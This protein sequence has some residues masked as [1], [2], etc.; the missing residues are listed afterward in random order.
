MNATETVLSAALVR[1]RRAAT[2]RNAA[3]PTARA[4]ALGVYPC[5][6]GQHAGR[7]S[8]C[9]RSCRHVPGKELPAPAFHDGRPGASPPRARVRGCA[10][11]QAFFAI[12]LSLCIIGQTKL[13]EL[14]HP[15][16]RAE[17]RERLASWR[18]IM[19]SVAHPFRGS[20]ADSGEVM[21][22]GGR[23]QVLPA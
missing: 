15:Q 17:Y 12:F 7:S 5:R 21:L 18:S 6:A 4:S 19:S 14:K 2:R 23:Y 1:P 11:L 8:V 3:E 20:R 13:R 22:D 9:A 10:R 16:H